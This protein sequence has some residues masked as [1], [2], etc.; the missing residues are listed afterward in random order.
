MY[1]ILSSFLLLF[2]IYGSFRTTRDKLHETFPIF[3]YFIGAHLLTWIT[4][5]MT[6]ENNIDMEY[7][8]RFSIYLEMFAIIPQLILIYKQRSID[9]TMTYYL[10]MLGTYRA[11]YIINWIDRYQDDGF[12]EPISFFS[13]CVQ[14]MIYLHFFFHIYPRV[15]RQIQPVEISKV[16]IINDN[17]NQKTENIVPLI[18][19]VV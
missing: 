17:T 7:L 19:N 13:G 2:L 11:F 6:G 4:S 1:Y 5:Y 12:W 16:M 18:H 9:V 8:W 3:G 14:T 10:M 15:S